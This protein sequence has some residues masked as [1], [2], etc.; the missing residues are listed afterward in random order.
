MKTS[1]EHFTDLLNFFERNRSIEAC[2]SSKV[3]QTFLTSLFKSELSP[4]TDFDLVDHFTVSWLEKPQEEK[5]DSKHFPDFLSHLLQFLEANSR[6]YIIVL[7]IFFSKLNTDVKGK[8]F[9][10]ISGNECEK[11]KKLTLFSKTNAELGEFISSHTKNSR[12]PDFFN[13]PLLVIPIK[14]HSGFVGFQAIY[15]AK[16]FFSV[17]RTFWMANDM[18]GTLGSFESIFLSSTAAKKNTHL[19]IWG[20]EH[21][22]FS[23]SPLRFRATFPIKLQFV[24]KHKSQ[25][26]TFVKAAISPDSR[27]EMN[28]KFLNALIILNKG[29]D[30]EI[31][32]EKSLALL[33]Y[34]SA[35]ES[36]VC[37]SKGEK[38]LRLASL[39]PKLACVKS[40][41][42]F[43]FSKAL[44]LMYEM[45][46]NF[47]H[48]AKETTID[49]SSIGI[50]EDPLVLIRS[51]LAKIIIKHYDKKN[52]F[53]KSFW[54][55]KVD[56]EFQRKVFGA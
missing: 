50:D 29:Y 19:A 6:D 42:R 2:Y 47:V 51:C 25:I 48:A 35:A 5:V 26:D 20:K 17:L 23:H 21:G 43:L 53:P 41:K 28:E 55:K 7:P 30:L 16:I 1:N 18:P 14:G 45:R 11:V 44:K 54:A 27:S 22:D 40:E 13:H 36:L 56:L 12:S 39:V 37:E 24:E 38:S 15:L 9:K 10:I 52:A 31:K 34:I 32:G 46:N 4:K 33:I 49:L 3:Y 8:T